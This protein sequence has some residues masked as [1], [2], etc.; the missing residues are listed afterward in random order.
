MGPFNTLDALLNHV[1]NV[2]RTLLPPQ[3]RSSK[4]PLPSQAVENSL[5]LTTAEKKHVAGL[6]RV[7]HAGEI[8]AQALYQGQGLTA[9]L[10][11]IKIQMAEAAAEETDHLAWCEHRLREL[12]NHPSYLNPFW[13]LGSLILGAVAG[14]AG[15]RW[16]LGFVAETEKQVSEHL[17]QHL[18]KLPTQDFK[19]RAILTQMYNDEMHHAETA[20]NAGGYDLPSPLKTLMALVAKLMTKTSYYW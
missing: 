14:L 17:Q 10:K 11:D 4:R 15:D 19:T 9:Q 16:S 2:L 3:Q 7:N 5:P 18:K 20:I 1:D 6:M 13:Y 12:N 8:C